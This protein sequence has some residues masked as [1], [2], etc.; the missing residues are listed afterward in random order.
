M[1]VN[2]LSSKSSADISSYGTV[3]TSYVNVFEVY[4]KRSVTVKSLKFTMKHDASYG[5]FYGSLFYVGDYATLTL[6]SV[7]VLGGV[8]TYTGSTV[9]LPFPIVDAEDGHLVLKSTTFKNLVM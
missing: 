6:D 8:A 3:G 9:G 2:G 1:T 5:G 7:E 4:S